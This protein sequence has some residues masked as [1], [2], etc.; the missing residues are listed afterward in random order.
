MTAERILDAAFKS[1]AAKGCG[2]VTLRGIAE[3]ADVALSQLNYYYGNKDGLF[4]AVLKRMKQDYA[5]GLDRRLGDCDA[6]SDRI[7]VLVD[8]NE[9][10]LKESIDTYRNFLEFFNFAMNS[11]AFR[12]EVAAFLSDISGMIE[13]RITRSQ[14]AR[15]DPA[16]FSPAMITRFI[17][18]GS[19]GISMQHLLSPENTDVRAGFEI[20]KATTVMISQ[21]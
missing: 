17:L 14:G 13:A 16:P 15:E 11:D 8:Y 9:H 12:A 4:A 1:I 20:I 3:E 5:I 7:K 6:L 2:A 19:F 21:K 18:S 10:L